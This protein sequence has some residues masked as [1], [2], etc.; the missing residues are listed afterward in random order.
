MWML[1]DAEVRSAV[2]PTQTF[3][4]VRFSVA[5]LGIANIITLRSTM[6]D[7]VP[8]PVRFDEFGNVIQLTSAA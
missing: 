2:G 8:R 4:D 6:L 3:P 7:T 1:D 5:M